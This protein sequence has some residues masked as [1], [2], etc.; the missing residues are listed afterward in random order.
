VGGLVFC[1]FGGSCCGFVGFLFGL[2]SAGLMWGGFFLFGGGL[3]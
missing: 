3:C 2:A 1:F